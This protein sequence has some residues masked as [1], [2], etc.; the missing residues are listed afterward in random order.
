YCASL[1]KHNAEQ[2][3]QRHLRDGPGVAPLRR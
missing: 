1:E 2:P 3:V